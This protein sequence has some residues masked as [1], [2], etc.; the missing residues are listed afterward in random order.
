MANSNQPKHKCTH[1]MTTVTPPHLTFRQLEALHL[2]FRSWTVHGD[3][4]LNVPVQEHP[5]STM[6]EWYALTAY[7]QAWYDEQ[8]DLMYDELLDA[9]KEDGEDVEA[10]GEDDFE[11]FVESVDLVLGV[12]MAG[13]QDVEDVDYYEPYFRDWAEEGFWDWEVKM[14]EWEVEMDLEDASEDGEMD[15]EDGDGDLVVVG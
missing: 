11:A 12:R 2:G 10:W 6:A 9:A 15:V 14:R 8:W 5:S 1:H 13:V 3:V 4:F 7:T